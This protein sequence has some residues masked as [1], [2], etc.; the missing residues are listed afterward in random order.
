MAYRVA[1]EVA[2]SS[3][4]DRGF[5]N[6]NYGGLIDQHR[7]VQTM[8]NIR[9]LVIKSKPQQIKKALG[10][11]EHA[12]NHLRPESQVMVYKLKAYCAAQEWF[13]ATRVTEETYHK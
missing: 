8:C 4:A 10:W 2:E 9:D 13:L 7:D 6:L 3:D 1:E 11:V 5:L 12:L